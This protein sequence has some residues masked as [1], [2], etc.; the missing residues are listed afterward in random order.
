MLTNK[1]VCQYS[2]VILCVSPAPEMWTYCHYRCVDYLCQKIECMIE[3]RQNKVHFA[4]IPEGTELELFRYIVRP[5]SYDVSQ[6]IFHL[7]CFMKTYRGRYSY[8]IYRQLYQRYLG[9]SWIFY[10]CIKLWCRLG[11]LRMFDKIAW[12]KKAPCPT[13]KPQESLEV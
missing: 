8:H 6:R 5:D 9:S 2:V 10:S 3:F 11:L 1:S 4:W 13:T 12:I 7:M